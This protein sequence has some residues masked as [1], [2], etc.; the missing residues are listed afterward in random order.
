MD[1]EETETTE[2]TRFDDQEVLINDA[3]ARPSSDS[4]YLSESSMKYL[5][6]G[7]TGSYNERHLQKKIEGQI[8]QLSVRIR[9]LVYDVAALDYGGYLD[10]VD[11]V[12]DYLPRLSKLDHL[13]IRTV[14]G[15]DARTDVS[16]SELQ[17]GFSIGLAFSTITGTLS[18]SEQAEEF[19][20]GFALAYE[21]DGHYSEQESNSEV[22]NL[23]I[24][25]S[26]ERKRVL[27]ENNIKHN[28]YIDR[29][30][31][32]H[33]VGWASIK[34]EE[35]KP[36]EEAAREFVEEWLGDSFEQYRRLRSKLDEEWDSIQD[37]SVPGAGAEEVLQALWELSSDSQ[38]TNKI[39]SKNIGEHMEGPD[40]Y[41]GTVSHVL[42]Q[43]SKEGK[44]PSAQQ[45]PTYRYGGIVEW[46]G[47]EWEFTEY[48]R[49]LA[50]YVF[51][52]GQRAEWIQRVALRGTLPTEEEYQ[53]PSDSQRDILSRGL[54]AISEIDSTE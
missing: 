15:R 37:A 27:E 46:S 6:T 8:R 29:L 24:S 39:K 53:S 43:L 48:G 17:L 47:K 7:E 3:A 45:E 33:N 16:N 5:L 41:E 31:Q 19:L 30:V 11:E 22:E 20:N 34:N 10:D 26:N 32:I 1:K 50:Y 13:S 54:E 12:C 51:K 23:N 14:Q 38:F 44:T 52:K 25:H 2:Y 36:P 21:T 4:N 40:T 42:N 18:E 28:N 9:R 35:K 49:L